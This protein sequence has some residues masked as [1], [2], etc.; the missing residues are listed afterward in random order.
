MLFT[1][2][3]EDRSASIRVP[4]STVMQRCGHYEDRRPASNMDPY[5]VTMMLVCTTLGIPLPLAMER[6][7]MQDESSSEVASRGSSALID[8]IDHHG[9]A[10]GPSTP[11]GL[12]GPLA[13]ECNSD[14]HS[15]T[16]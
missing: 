3:I 5:L 1:A 12:P 6:R 8:E 14:L 4:Q 2:G 9:H 7:D 13:S 10:L 16:G 15:F 11:D